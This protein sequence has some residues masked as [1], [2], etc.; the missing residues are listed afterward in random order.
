MRVEPTKSRHAV[1]MPPLGRRVAAG[2]APDTRLFS[3]GI[4]FQ[5]MQNKASAGSGAATERDQ[6]KPL[7]LIA[8]MEYMLL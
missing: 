5:D 4:V 2:P 3:L 8:F 7:N 6:A 1:A